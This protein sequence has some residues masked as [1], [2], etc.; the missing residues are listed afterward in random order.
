MK[1]TK[2]LILSLFPVFLFLFI[3]AACQDQSNL[4]NPENSSLNTTLKKI[5]D[6]DESIRSFEPN[7]NEGEALQLFKGLAKEIY[8]V[9]IGQRLKIVSSDFLEVSKTDAEALYQ[10]TQVFEG[11]LLI[12]ATG[13]PP[14]QGQPQTTKLYTKPIK[15]TVTRFI[16]YAKVNNTGDDKVDWKIIAVSLPQGGTAAP[17]VNI[18]KVKLETTDGKVVEIT[19]PNQYFF[20]L[21]RNNGIGNNGNGMMSGGNGMHGNRGGMMGGF[22]TGSLMSFTARQQ[23]KITVTVESEYTDEDF[24]TLT[25]GA[26]MMSGA[27]NGMMNNG[28]GMM[29]GN[30]MSIGNNFAGFNTGNRLKEKFDIKDVKQVNG[31]YVRTYEK[32]WSANFNMGFMHA[33]INAAPKTSIFDDT[34][35]AEENTWGI[36]YSVK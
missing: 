3:A 32:L 34:A 27:G 9:K 24:I 8:P 30:S 6:N 36:P 31:K 14:A 7:Y 1:R 10:L 13:T 28:S 19:N 2:S 29:N 21:G 5:A 33:V 26:T 17:K 35:L 18:V 20:E 16:K 25:Y 23:V 11:D 15:T 4:V 22:G 12:Y